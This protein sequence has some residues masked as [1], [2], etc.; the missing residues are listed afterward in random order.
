MKKILSTLVL[1]LL[2]AGVASA[3][4]KEQTAQNRL[5]GL[6][7]GINNM[8]IADV[9]AK[10]DLQFMRILV[11]LGIGIQDGIQKF[12]ILTGAE[13]ILAEQALPFGV[14]GIISYETEAKEF[15][16]APYFLVEAE[17]LDN[18]TLGLNAG[19]GFDKVDSN[20]LAIGLFTRAELTFYFL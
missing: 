18:V 20:D 11:G 19:L 1:I 4:E 14:G 2:F 6:S 12:Q 10:I 8:N 9:E 5:L 16:L 3:Q 7:V 17:L 13:V 15:A